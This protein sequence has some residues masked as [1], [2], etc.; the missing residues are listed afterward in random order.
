MG[1]QSSPPRQLVSPDGQPFGP[2]IDTIREAAKRSGIRL[3]WVLAPEGPD[4][5]MAAHKVDLWPLLADLPRRR[6]TIYLSRA[7]IHPDYFLVT[8]KSRG[9]DS[10][11]K[12]KG[13][14]ISYTHGIAGQVVQPQV[15]Q[16]ILVSRPDAASSLHAVCT[17]EVDGAVTADDIVDSSLAYAL[18]GCGD[19]DLIPIDISRGAGVGANPR[20]SEA[21]RAADAIRASIGDMARDGALTGI[22][23]RW[24][25]HPSQETLML[26]YLNSETR[27]NHSLAFALGLLTVA[28]GSLVWLAI[29]LRGAKLVAERAS[30]ARSQFVAN[31]SH[32]I[33]TPMNGIVGMTDLALGTEL[34]GEQR[35]YLVTARTAA[36]QLLTLLNDILDISKIEAGGI[37][38]LP[39]DFQ[40]RDCVTDSLHTLSARAEEKGL[41][42]LC[43][44][45]PDVPDALVG[46]AGRL[47]QILINVVGNAIKF[48]ERGEV[49]VEVTLE[50]VI[51]DGA[52]LQFRVADTG[53]GIPAEKQLLV[54]EAFKQ[55]DASMTRKY[56]GTGL[57][58]SISARLVGLMGGRIWLESPRTDL[59]ADAP[60]PG[61]AFHFLVAMGLR[62]APAALASLPLAGAPVLIV[63]GNQ[64]S[65]AILVETLRARWMKPVAVETGEAALATLSQAR[66]AG[67]PFPLAILDLRMRDMDGFTLAACI[68]AQAELRDTRLFLLTAAGRRVD[69]ARSKEI[70]FELCLLKPVKESALL[71]AMA[72]ALGAPAPGLPAAASETLSEPRHQLRILLAEDNPVN[73][74]LAV[75]LLQKQGHLVKIANDGAEAV[76]AV[77]NAAFD[78]VLMDVQMPNMSG[79]EATSAIRALEPPGGRHLPIVAMTAHA[80]KGDRERCLEAGMDG[81]VSKPIRLQDMLEAIARVT[82]PAAEKCT[83]P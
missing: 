17:G 33:R 70:G 64:T 50:P 83:T 76:A 20:D 18:S 63:D 10:V 43:R 15:P 57:G 67:S 78:L 44:I 23:L 54:F 61:C 42:L 68:R 27:L 81:Y 8:L 73:Q 77:R 46:D 21:V 29:R 75:R 48:T 65:R 52:M 71:D 13:R 41:S 3:Q 28:F 72:H 32:E 25:A 55:A 31:M 39:A 66:A 36:G 58:L 62:P 26:E 60:G 22:Y 12:T 40:L 38:I 53:I 2:T 47:R 1:F 9:I 35:D 51:G 16:A 45:A 14:T 59:P 82:S 80:M 79:L 6:G 74:K 56:G 5:A 37:D 11:E 34:T 7:Y 19:F 24:F 49:A 30:A 4:A 69:A